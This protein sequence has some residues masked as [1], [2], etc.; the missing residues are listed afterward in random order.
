MFPWVVL[1]GAVAIGG[2]VLDRISSSIEED[3]EEAEEELA[4]DRM[5]Y[6]REIRLRNARLARNRRIKATIA[7]LAAAE[8]MLLLA[9]K[10]EGIAVRNARCAAAGARQSQ[11]LLAQAK[12]CKVRMP[13]RSGS[14]SVALAAKAESVEECVRRCRRKT[15]ACRRKLAEIRARRFSFTCSRCG[16]RFS[17]SAERLESFLAMRKGGRVRC[18]EC[19]GRKR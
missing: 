7:E 12:A 13:A 2:Y 5:A 8:K 15:A 17:V 9:Q 3:N 6:A 4:R 1:G 19:V 14:L 10:A 16:R 18:P 11:K